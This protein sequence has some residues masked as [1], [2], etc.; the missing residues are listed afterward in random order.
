ME[1]RFRL[2]T[3]RLKEFLETWKKRRK[4]ISDLC[5]NIRQASKRLEGLDAQ[6]QR[7]LDELRKRQAHE[8]SVLIDSIESM[9]DEVVIKRANLKQWFEAEDPKI[10]SFARIASKIWL[11]PRRQIK[12]ALKIIRSQSS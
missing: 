7:E 8:K 10:H 5:V 12:R 11:S 4:E 9:K 2:L 1:G 6:Q 3:S